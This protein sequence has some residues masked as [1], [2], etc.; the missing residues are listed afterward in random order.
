MTATGWVMLAITIFGA[1]AYA[2]ASIFQALGARRATS[3]VKAFGHPLYPD[4]DPRATLLLDLA[5]DVNPVAVRG[6]TALKCVDRAQEELGLKANLPMALAVLCAV[7][8]APVGAPGALGPHLADAAADHGV[9][10]GKADRSVR[11]H[12]ASPSGRA[13]NRGCAS[14]PGAAASRR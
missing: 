7:L 1:F 5:R 12:A 4:G 9:L 11:A 10:R 6:R 2:A 3:T 14:A 13:A 8:A